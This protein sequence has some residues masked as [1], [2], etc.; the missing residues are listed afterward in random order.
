MET[1]EEAG[2][3]RALLKDARYTHPTHSF[4]PE[5]GDLLIGS[6]FLSY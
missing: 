1:L 2:D 6:F 5:E 4:M 3:T